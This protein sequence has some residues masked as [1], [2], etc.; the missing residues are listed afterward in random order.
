MKRA[1]LSLG[2]AMVT[3]FMA[4]GPTLA[5]TMEQAAK[6]EIEIARSPQYEQLVSKAST[7]R[8]INRVVWIG[9]RLNEAWEDYTSGNYAAACAKY[10]VVKNDLNL[11]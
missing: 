5:C 4:S 10:D 9:K 3:I 2:V 7:A 11:R 6:M 8:Q 1:I